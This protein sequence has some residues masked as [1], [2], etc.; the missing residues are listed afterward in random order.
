M[1]TLYPGNAHCRIG[2]WALDPGCRATGRGCNSTA[3]D[4]TLRQCVAQL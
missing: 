4:A 2:R 1:R 3:A